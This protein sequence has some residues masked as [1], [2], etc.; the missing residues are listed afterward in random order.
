MVTKFYQHVLTLA[1]AVKT[2]N[3]NPHILPNVT[4]GFHIYD[5]YYYELMAYR[6]FLDLLS[7]SPRF[8]P[9]YECGTEINLKAIIGGLGSDISFHLAELL[10]AYK[11]PQVRNEQGVVKD[12]CH[13]GMVDNRLTLFLSR[14]A[15]DWIVLKEEEM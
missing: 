5:T 14:R 11:I 15:G 7:K 10:E 9:N 2:L 8:L 13:G 6:T 4:L 12:F 1:F 3:E